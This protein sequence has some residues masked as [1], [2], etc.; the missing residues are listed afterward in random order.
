MM[1]FKT[2][3][4]I[5]DYFIKKIKS[6]SQSEINKI[7]EETENLRHRKIKEIEDG[8]KQMA[9][10]MKEQEEKI[11]K[12]EHLLEISTKSDE[13]NQKKI[14][15]REKMISQLFDSIK[16]RL[17]EYSKSEEYK[18]SFK[19]KL[20]ELSNKYK[21]EFRIL[22]AFKDLQLAK[23]CVSSISNVLEVIVDESVEIGGFVA[24]F[25]Q[26]SVIINETLDSKL[27]DELARFYENP[28]LVLF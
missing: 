7:I 1:E 2:N 23:D 25:Q 9:D 21:Q 12:S 24:E 15:L 4:D 28:Q 11:L 13:F 22:V 8:A 17:I 18:D 19:E 10:L 27:E 3:E 26:T 20:A 16:E 6:A 5:R 14:A